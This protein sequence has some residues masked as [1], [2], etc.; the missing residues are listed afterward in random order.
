M[1]TI[2]DYPNYTIDEYGKIYNCKHKRFIKPYLNKIGYYQIR[3]TN[4]KGTKKLYLHRLL[5]INFIDNSLNKSCI[6][7][8]NGIKSDNRLENLEWATYSENSK[9]A[10][11]TGLNPYTENHYNGIRKSKIKLVLDMET[12]IYYDSVVEASY[13]KNLN[14]NTLAG[15]LSGHKR[16]FTLLKYV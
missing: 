1:Q 13:A 10:C 5:A 8:I 15:K 16:N 11:K 14:K 6:N 9:H 3:L 2:K 12:G 4:E 7:H